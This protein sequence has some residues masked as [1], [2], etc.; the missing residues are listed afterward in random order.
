MNIYDSS[1]GSDEDDDYF[2]PRKPR[3]FKERINFQEITDPQQYME[4]F[5]ICGAAMEEVL[6]QI[7]SQLKHE[8]NRNHALSPQQQLM[9][10]LHWMGNGSQY[11]GVVDMHGLHKSTTHR[12]VRRVTSLIHR[13]LFPQEVRW[14]ET[15]ALSIAQGFFERAGFPKVGGCIDG[16]LIP[17]DGPGSR[18]RGFVD[19]KGDHSINCMAVCGPDHQFYFASARWPGSVHDS[20]ILRCSSL[21]EEWETKGWRPFP[22]ALLLGDS[23]YPLLGWLLTPVTRPGFSDDGIRRYLRRHKS[24]RCI[25]ECAFGILKEK[26]PCLNELRLRPEVAGR[27]ILSCM[28]LHNIQKRHVIGEVN[29]DMWMVEGKIN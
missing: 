6:G 22:G 27:V 17:I 7:G 15:G 5:R 18:E 13:Q 2:R 19:R 23:G 28:T 29:N 10:A 3:H 8:T 20:R 12:C 11:H 25:V 9:T 1:S 24:T 14:P 16:S 4:K 21:F 26:F